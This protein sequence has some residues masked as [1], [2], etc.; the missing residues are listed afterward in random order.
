MQNLEAVMHPSHDLYLEM[1]RNGGK[2]ELPT[3]TCEWAINNECAPMIAETE[4]TVHEDLSQA[5]NL[6]KPKQHRCIV[7]DL[8]AGEVK[9]AVKD[10]VARNC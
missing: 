5:R 10:V 9:C 4:A 7:Q 1:E 2:D 8:T 3:L 6:E